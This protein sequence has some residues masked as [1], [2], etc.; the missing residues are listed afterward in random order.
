MNN[1]FIPVFL[2]NGINAYSMAR[3]FHE[4]YGVRDFKAKFGGQEVEHGRFLYISKPLLYKFG[5]LGVKILKKL[6]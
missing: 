2:G 4:A 1:D 6:K 3:A 5:V